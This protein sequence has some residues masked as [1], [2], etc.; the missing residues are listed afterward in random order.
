MLKKTLIALVLLS[1]LALTVT[2]AIAE[3]PVQEKTKKSVEMGTK[4]KAHGW[5]IEFS[6]V[7]VDCFKIPVY[8]KVAMY[9]EFPNRQK[10]VDK[11]IELK[12]IAINKYEG[13]SDAIEILCNV[14]IKVGC[15][16]VLTDDGKKI[17]DDTG[18]W[19]CRVRDDQTW[20]DDQPNVAATGP[21]PKAI[22]YIGVRVSDPKL[23]DNPFDPAKPKK[24]VAEAI[25]RVKPDI[26]GAQW[27]P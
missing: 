24:K 3:D 10:V 14:N 18:K 4:M 13:F 7:E 15:K 27:D 6:W 25:V 23:L 12:Q 11:G 2:P 1:I 8:M 21:S 17:Q 9:I 19:S 26:E 22:K 20:G 16:C 5:P